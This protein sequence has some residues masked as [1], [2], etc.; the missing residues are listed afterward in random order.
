[1]APNVSGQK[2]VD[3]PQSVHLVELAWDCAQQIL[4][5]GGTFL[6]KIFQ[7]EGVDDLVRELKKHFKTVRLRKPKSS[8]PRS[9]EFYILGIG[10]QV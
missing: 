3:Q 9:P 5:P 10:F 1:M 7:G 4:Q 2:S 6:A 8:R